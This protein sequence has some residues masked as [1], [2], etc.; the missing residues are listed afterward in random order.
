VGD[1]ASNGRWHSAGFSWDGEVI[2]VGWEPG[3]GGAGECEIT[4]PDLDKSL[5]FY[6]AS[7]GEALGRWVLDRSQ[8]SDENCT[9][10]NYNMIP[11][12]NG[13]DVVVMGNYQAGVWVVDFTD[14]TSPTTVGWIDPVS[15]GPGP[16]CGG[17]CQIGGSWST[18]WYNNF[19]YDSDITRGLNVFGLSDRA[20][21]GAMRL[22]GLNPQTQEFTID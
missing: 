19:I 9:I 14:P 3:G 13:N 7:T 17:N 10:H 21:A 5:F 2:V 20:R 16:F 1:S 15:L 8:G 11:L 18:Y 6:D 4:D 12:R 22:E